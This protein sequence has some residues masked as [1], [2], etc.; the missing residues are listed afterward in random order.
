MWRA[1]RR[2]PPCLSPSGLSASG[3]AL[4]FL[5][6]TRP[7]VVRRGDLRDTYGVE[8]LPRAPALS[9]S[10]V[11]AVVFLV[12]LLSAT[13]TAST[14]A[15]AYD[16][17]NL[18]PA[19]GSTIAYA[20]WY[21]AGS[22]VRFTIKPDSNHP[23]ASEYYY[24]EVGGRRVGRFGDSCSTSVYLPNRAVTRGERSSTSSKPGPQSRGQSQLSPCSLRRHLRLHLPH[25]QRLRPS[26]E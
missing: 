19:N 4:S 16:F 23:C 26:T 2:V 12:V 22:Y 6:A 13:F 10:R 11:F 20:D 8:A 17:A 21:N 18:E 7:D 25:Q 3:H 14:R 24:L 1:C 15:D 9:R 5:I